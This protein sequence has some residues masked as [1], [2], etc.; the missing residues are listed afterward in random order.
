MVWRSRIAAW[1]DPQMA[2]DAFEMRCLRRGASLEFPLQRRIHNQRVRLRQLE[3][4]ARYPEDRWRRWM[5][6]ALRLGK[7]NNE[8]RRSQEDCGCI[9]AHRHDCPAV[10]V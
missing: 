9:D 1:L 8:L 10:G 4:F 3:E 6:L 5:N 7:E 2:K